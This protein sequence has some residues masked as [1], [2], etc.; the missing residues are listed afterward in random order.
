MSIPIK[1]NPLGIN[2]KNDYRTPLTLTALEDNSSVQLVCVT[3]EGYSGSS[4]V[5][6]SK[7]Y[8][9]TNESNT[10][11]K[12][13]NEV[14]NLYNEGDYVQFVNSNNILSISNLC[15]ANFVMTGKIAGSGNVQS[16]LN[17]QKYVYSYSFY[18]LFSGC[19]SLI[20]SPSFPGKFPNG[21][22]NQYFD[23]FYGC[24][25]L[26]EAPDL[27]TE[28]I[29]GQT[30]CRM[31]YNCKSLQYPPKMPKTI[32]ITNSLR[33][34]YQMFYGCSSLRETPEFEC[35]GTAYNGCF[36][37]MFEG[38]TSLKVC[39]IKLSSTTLG[40]SCYRGMFYNCKLD[41]IPELPATTLSNE[42]YMRM[43]CGCD[44]EEVTLPATVLADYCYYEMF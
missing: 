9:R 29:H 21:H 43:F 4:S 12:Y 8:Y 17:F 18:G 44:I 1:L 32:T 41:E 28:D 27:M 36:Q 40:P 10:W 19:T 35:S 11:L 33:H 39:K 2:K 37:S 20:Y 38:C 25:N 13:N 31:F 14:V 34:C 16:L 15:F 42:C 5:D 3:N 7:M 30:Y 6:F 26:L 24:T 22:S 23:T